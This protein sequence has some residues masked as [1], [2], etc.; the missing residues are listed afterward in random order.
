MKVRTGIWAA[1]TA[2]AAVAALYVPYANGEATSRPS[3]IVLTPIGDPAVSAAV[4][5]RASAAASSASAQIAPASPGPDIE[6]N[7]TTV[8]ASSRA[9]TV[10]ETTYRH[11]RVTFANL[12][13][14]TLYAY[15]VA[16]GTSWSE[17]FQFRTAAREPKPYRFIYLGDEQ[18]DIR[19]RC[20]R[21]VRQALQDC[22]DAR[23][24]LHGG[25]L[26]NTASSDQEWAEWFDM[27]GWASA[28]ILNV[29]A[30][31]NHQ[32]ERISPT[33]EQ[34][35]LTPHWNAI[36]ELP[37][38]GV[39]EL[40]GSSYT[41][42]YQGVRFVVL[43]TMEK[44]VE[45]A[46]WLDTLLTGNPCRWTV[47]M[48]HHPIY[49]GAKNRDNAEIRAAL[50]PILDHHR[51]DLVLTGHDHVYGRSNPSSGPAKGHTVY[52]TSV[53]GAKQYDAGN[54]DWAARFG[55]DLQLY[56]IIAVNGSLLTFQ[57]RTADGRLYDAFELRKRG[58]RTNFLD[59][60]GSLGPERLRGG[61][62]PATP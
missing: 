20:A 26:T 10:G 7:A 56:Q 22:P 17:W 21:V 11:Y 15:R 54:R 36:F 16:N 34:R 14:D 12:R 25:D 27:L 38:N 51:V 2:V 58:S 4:T 43:N 60:S 24:I 30:I 53:T 50:K 48:F 29:P 52:V 62:K 8:S 13:P 31:G 49:S 44:I 55:Q 42:D 61:V 5:W 19:G 37:H 18:T 40:E 1:L 28:S 59:R 39:R 47:V 6:K 3:H 33:S 32:Y 9:L 45:Q 35:R 41:F 46:A 57:A 23:L